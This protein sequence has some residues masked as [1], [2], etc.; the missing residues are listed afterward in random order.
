MSDE[1][2]KR[3][4]LLSTEKR[5]LLEMLMK[6]D[7]VSQTT[8]VAP[9]TP[10]E[11][12]LAN[13]WSQV[14]GIER[15]GIHDNFL[16]LGGD[17]IQSI[18]VVA[19]V[20]QVGIQL[21]SNQLFEYP[22]I[23]ELATVVGI[24]PALQAQQ[25]SVIGPVPLTPIQRWFFEQNLEE[26]HHWNQA[27][28]L[29]VQPNQNPAL[30]EQ[31]FGQLLIQ[32]DAL[33][34]RYEQKQ[35]IWQQ[36]NQG[37]GE[38]VSFSQFDLSQIAESEQPLAIER[39]ATELQSSL[40]LCE[41]P[42]MKVAFFN[43]GDQKPDR[44]LLIVHHL[45]VDGV[46]FRIMLED[47]QTVYQQ[48][49]RGEAIFLPPKTT[50][51]QQWSDLMTEYANSQELKQEL[52]YWLT[53]S[54]QTQP[55]PIDFIEGANTE[56]STG[57]VS[58]SL[59][60]QE[61]QA[62]LQETPAVYRTQINEV[63]LTSVVQAVCQWTGT[64]TLLIDLEGHGREAVITS[65]DTSRT[66]G[67]FTSV[68][69]V[70]LNLEKVDD[71]L[72][73]LR[74]VKEQL[75]SIPNRGIGYGW[76]RYCSSDREII[77]KLSALSQAEISLNYLGQFDRVFAES[78]TFQVAQESYGATNSPK[79]TRSHLLQIIGKVIGRE[80]QINWVYSKNIHR[81]DT[82]ENLAQCFIETL[83]S[84]INQSYSNSSNSFTPSDFPEA[85]LSQ[86]QLDRLFR[87]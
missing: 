86:E 75:R 51:F 6:E 66:V 46:S 15:V 38:T 48:L 55:I 32:H 12:E 60:P 2:L 80:L 71:L 13:I 53:Q 34:L 85:E 17:S 45:V 1:L 79:A 40:N 87:N 14:L 25:E 65:V 30:L 62:L 22:T 5:E 70:H 74:S 16:E 83:R 47:F 67:W 8:Y 4:D 33:R 64:R 77:D 52:N 29:E 18:Q 81:R 69:P 56:E 76:L 44:L 73:T 37:L 63:L 19:K 54:R 24:N 36:S 59:T 82:V 50:S 11:E 49:T 43:I 10:V 57:I 42:L 7:I 26:L 9:R 58:V 61:T 68:F 21:T 3:I 72:N 20:N 39:I 27:V 41:G 35:G 23:A 31:A 78:A 28:L 84:L